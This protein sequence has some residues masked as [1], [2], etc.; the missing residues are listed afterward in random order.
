[1]KALFFVLLLHTLLNINYLF[2]QDHYEFMPYKK[3]T[4]LCKE[5]IFNIT[6]ISCN[7]KNQN[8]ICNLININ[9]IPELVAPKLNP[10]IYNDIITN[11][12]NFND[13]IKKYETYILISKIF[14]VFCNIMCYYFY[15][16]VKKNRE[17]VTTNKITNKITIKIIYNKDLDICT[18][19]FD[20]YNQ[21][22]DIRKIINCNHIYHYNCL[23]EWIVN[24]NNKTCPI[25]RLDLTN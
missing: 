25:C 15:F 17:T 14:C 16:K 1:M 21:S 4:Y 11:C 23:N 5:T 13:Y 19:C 12:K 20:D 22:S 8:L 7:K 6:P 9:N 3:N 24:Y 2:F 10:V 18:I